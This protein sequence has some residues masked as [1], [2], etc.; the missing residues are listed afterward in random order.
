MFTRATRSLPGTF[1]TVALSLVVALFVSLSL[2]G[3]SSASTGTVE[4]PGGSVEE[5]CPAMAILFKSE[6]KWLVEHQPYFEPDDPIMVSHRTQYWNYWNFL[7]THCG[8][9]PVAH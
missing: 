4:V 9:A 3:A 7:E 6:G 2:I 5:I 8:G 1:R